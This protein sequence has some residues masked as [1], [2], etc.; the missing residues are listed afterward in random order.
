MTRVGHGVVSGSATR[1]SGRLLSGSSATVSVPVTA[2]TV[3]TV[4]GTTMGNLGVWVQEALEVLP[5]LPQRPVLR[6]ESERWAG[7]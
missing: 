3:S 5:R 1:T 2:L 4:V 6:L 7:I